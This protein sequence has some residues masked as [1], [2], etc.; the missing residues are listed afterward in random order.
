MGDEVLV[1]NSKVVS[2]LDMVF[3]ETMLQEANSLCLTIRSCRVERPVNTTAMMEHAD[4][5]I[6]N[7]M[8]P[9]P[10][11]QTRISD[12]SIS[13]LIVPAPNWGECLNVSQ[14]II[15]PHSP[16]KKPNTPQHVSWEIIVIVLTLIA[17]DFYLK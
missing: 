12:K 14:F 5:Y 3:V 8:C 11:S 13:E 1:I 10:P 15:F 4:M 9:P 7:L 16:P 2:D 6:D 17:I